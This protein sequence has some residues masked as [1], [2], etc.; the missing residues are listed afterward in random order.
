MLD[1]HKHRRHSWDLSLKRVELGLCSADVDVSTALLNRGGLWR[2]TTTKTGHGLYWIVFHSEALNMYRQ[3][4]NQSLSDSLRH[5]CQI[6]RVAESAFENVRS[7]SFMT[8]SKVYVFLFFSISSVVLIMRKQ[9]KGSTEMEHLSY[10]IR[11]YKE[12]DFSLI[13]GSIL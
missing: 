5:T 11:C 3:K 13:S 6:I 10:F 4:N 8:I 1:L 7:P 12:V 2:T 9:L